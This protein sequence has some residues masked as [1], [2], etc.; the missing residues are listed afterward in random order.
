MSLGGDANS[1]D[2]RLTCIVA[3]VVCFS[4]TLLFHIP[5]K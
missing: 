3:G 1:E 5:R 2:P 4:M